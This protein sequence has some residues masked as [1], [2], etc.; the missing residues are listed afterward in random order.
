MQCTGST[1]TPSQSKI[2]KW[3]PDRPIRILHVVGGMERGG[4]ET[5]LMHILRNI[6]RNRFQMDFLVHTSR[7]CAYD[8]EIRSLG[9]RIIPCLYPQRPLQYAYH[10]KQILHQY[11]PYDVV[12][13]HVHYFSGYVL[14]IARQAGISV[15]IAHSHNDATAI[16]KKAKLHRRIYFALTKHWINRYASLGLACSRQAA[17]H[18]FGSSWATNSQ[19]QILYFGID[20]APFQEQIDP[21]IVRAEYGIPPNSFVIGHAGRFVTQKNHKFL[22]EVAKAVFQR[23]PNAYLLL[24]GEG[25]L[26]PDIEHD[27]TSQGLT[28]RV[29]FAG[30]RPD[31]HR[32]MKGAMD[33]FLFPSLFEGLGLVLVEA[34]AAGVPC[35]VSDVVPE[36]ADIIKPMVQRLSLSQ[37]ISAWAEA[38]LAQRDVEPPLTQPDAHTHITASPFN[39]EQA[40]KQLETIYQSQFSY[41]TAITL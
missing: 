11:G 6:D 12:H 26:R 23:E 4:V 16:E 22:L 41:N 40:V 2:L 17:T 14:R 35:I 36:E 20:L 37:P 1:N 24:L 27:V 25:A 19:R 28:D 7:P 5:W 15:C 9:S 3:T 29:I 30:S 8:N 39:I 31:V 32:I 18:L 13:S 38:V 10:F 34:Q 33:V 21:A